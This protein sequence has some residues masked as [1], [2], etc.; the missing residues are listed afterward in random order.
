MGDSL[1]DLLSKDRFKEPPEI[2]IIKE[3]VHAETGITPNVAVTKKTFV[4]S[5]PNAAAAGTLRFRLFQLQ[6]RLGRD[7][8]IIIRIV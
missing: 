1:G 7:R 6:R 8:K 3:F 5:M 4:V 2:G